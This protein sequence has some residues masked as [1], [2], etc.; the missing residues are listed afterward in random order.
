MSR[1]IASFDSIDMATLAIKSVTRRVKGIDGVKINY[2]KVSTKPTNDV[3]SDFFITSPHSNG[4]YTNEVMC[5]PVNLAA[6]REKEQQQA[7]SYINGVQVELRT[8]S[9]DFQTIK[10]NLRQY[11]GQYVKVIG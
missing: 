1:V 5:P 10:S 7:H 3:L 4:I 8:K 6:V 9:S 2:Q 11:G